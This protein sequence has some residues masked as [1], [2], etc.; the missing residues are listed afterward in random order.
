MLR[1]GIQMVNTTRN[2][3]RITTQN[4]MNIP[5]YTCHDVIQSSKLV[6]TYKKGMEVGPVPS[7]YASA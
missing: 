2:K 5:E 6:H 7:T 4:T 3:W 1:P